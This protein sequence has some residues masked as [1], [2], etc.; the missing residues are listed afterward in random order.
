MVNER[1][2]QRTFDARE[3]MM[4]LRAVE[5]CCSQQND[6]RIRPQPGGGQQ[7][8]ATIM[9]RMGAWSLRYYD[10]PATAILNSCAN[11]LWTTLRAP[12]N[13]RSAA[14]RAHAVVRR[15]RLFEALAR[16][17]WL[18]DGSLGGRVGIGVCF[19]R[20]PS[21]FPRQSRIHDETLVV[22]WRDRRTG[23][24]S[25]F[26]VTKAHLLATGSKSFFFVTLKAIGRYFAGRPRPIDWPQ[27][28]VRR[29][30]Q[31][32]CEA[33]HYHRCDEGQHHRC[34][35]GQPRYATRSRLDA[36]ALPINTAAAPQIRSGWRR[37]R[38]QAPVLSYP[39]VLNWTSSKGGSSWLH[40][41]NHFTKRSRPALVC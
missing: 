27:A 34:D 19:R 10:P 8:I 6:G 2:I 12:S 36:F 17:V 15:D 21:S 16:S 37:L 14:A 3:L 39:R 9:T 32:G 22:V 31:H 25:F 13:R 24:L 41:S 1:L 40:S 23:R 33:S 30:T 29:A 35:E 20:S 38:D 5:Y 11:Y 18:T 26:E 28:R 4:E 7:D